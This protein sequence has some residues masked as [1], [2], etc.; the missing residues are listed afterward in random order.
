MSNAAP[1][2]RIGLDGRHRDR[3]GRIDRKHGNARIDHIRKKFPDFAPNV[4]GD[5]LLETYLKQIG[6]TSLS[7]AL[8]KKPWKPHKVV[9]I[10]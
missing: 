10:N 4:R 2:K 6:V 7:E 5:M 9:R 8:R 1:Q 3:D